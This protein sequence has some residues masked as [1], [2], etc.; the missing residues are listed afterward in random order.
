ML[1]FERETKN[2]IFAEESKTNKSKEASPR[3]WELQAGAKPSSFWEH[4]AGPRTIVIL[5]C[6]LR[7]SISKI[8]RAGGSIEDAR[9]CI[10]GGEVQHEN[11]SWL[12]IMSVVVKLVPDS[13]DWVIEYHFRSSKALDAKKS[14][15]SG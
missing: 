6:L 7:D 10:V 1:P 15:E 14:A 2:G 3:P 9:K 8:Q 5:K 12:G 4:L 11:L 13:L